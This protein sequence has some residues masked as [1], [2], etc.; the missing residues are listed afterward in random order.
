MIAVGAA[1]R[2]ATPL[3]AHGDFF[4]AMHRKR[5]LADPGRARR[6]VLEIEP[7]RCDVV[8]RGHRAEVVAHLDHQVRF[9][10]AH[11]VEVAHRAA[12]V[13]GQVG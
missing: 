1:E 7:G 9:A 10:A 8:N 2:G 6:L 13:A 4:D 12:G 3:V 11:Q 5:Q